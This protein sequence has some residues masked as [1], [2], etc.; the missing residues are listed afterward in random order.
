MPAAGALALR[1]LRAGP[2]APAAACAVLALL[3]AACGAAPRPARSP[4]ETPLP[5]DYLPLTLGPGPRYRPAATSVRVRAAAPIDGQRC[6]RQVGERFGAHLEVFAHQHV[7]AIPAGIGIAPPLA[8]GTDATVLGGRCSYPARTTDPTGVIDVRLGDRVTLGELF[9]IWGQALGKR[10]IARFRAPAG[11]VIVAYIDGR[12]FT[13][14]PRVIPL[15]RHER[16]VLEVASRVPPH[17]VYLFRKG[18]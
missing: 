13:A 11:S 17:R 14:D 4:A 18:L 8:L 16:I 5:P 9:D 3:I 1:R 6:T 2:F 15:V 12:R 10:V 7:V